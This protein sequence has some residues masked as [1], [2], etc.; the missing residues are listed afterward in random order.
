MIKWFHIKSKF[1]HIPVSNPQ[2]CS[3]HFT[4]YPLADLSN[5]SNQTPK[6]L[7]W[8]ASS[9]SA[10]NAQRLPMHKYPPLFIARYSFIHLSKLKQY[11]VKQLSHG[12]TQQHRIL[13]RVLLVES[14]STSHCTTVLLHYTLFI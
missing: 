11:G 7:H 13:T 5:D 14:Q 9:L 4:L 12:L 10:I 3:K 6:Q 8:E 1:L 2:D